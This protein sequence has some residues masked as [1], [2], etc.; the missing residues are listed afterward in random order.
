MKFLCACLSVLTLL[1]ACGKSD[2]SSSDSSGDGS[3][4][5][6]GSS[7]PSSDGNQPKKAVE[8]F[9]KPYLTEER[10]GNFMNSIKE[11]QT[12]FGILA[13]GGTM[14][15]L[16]PGI[17]LDEMNAFARK[18]K[19]A[20]AEEYIGAWGRVFATWMTVKMEESNKAAISTSETV[21]K[22]LEDELKKPDL[23]PEMR[24][25]LEEQVKNSR[26]QIEEL[27]KPQENEINKQDLEVMRKHAKEYEEALNERKKK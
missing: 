26:E 20:D 18:H 8:D 16:N 25:A 12:P 22:T 14:G 10:M 27:K 1:A 2:D 6:S 13:E 4:S 5:K 15:A 24:K 21:L 3:G 7:N 23:D 17:R 19:F 11:R 9:S